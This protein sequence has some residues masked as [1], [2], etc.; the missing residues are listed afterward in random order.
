[1]FRTAIRFLT[2]ILGLFEFFMLYRLIFD[3]PATMQAELSFYPTSFFED[4]ASK[5]AIRTFTAFLGLLRFIWATGNNSFLSWLGIVAAHVVEVIFLWNLARLPHFDP[6][7]SENFL[8]LFKKVQAGTVGQPSINFI[9]LFVPFL[10]LLL[11]LHGPGS[12]KKKHEKV[13]NH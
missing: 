1:M 10:L 9:L 2:L 13:K 7:G 3:S 11:V 5:F 8:E 12:W 6:Q 4:D